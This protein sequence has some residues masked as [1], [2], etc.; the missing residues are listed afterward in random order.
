MQGKAAVRMVRI[1]RGAALA[2]VLAV[3][4]A[5]L[6]GPVSAGRDFTVETRLAE[7]LK[8]LGLFRG[9]SDTDF[10]LERPLSRVESVVMLIRLLG[11]EEEALAQQNTHPFT[12]VPKWADAQIGYAYRNGLANGVSETEFGIGEAGAATYLTLVL[13]ALG[14]SDRN[15]EDFSWADPFP[16]AREAGIL[17]ELVNTTE[18]L[19]G[20]VVTVSYAA[21]AA[22]CKDSDETLSDRL[23]ASGVFSRELYLQQYDSSLFGNGEKAVLPSEALGML[24]DWIEGHYTRTVSEENDP[25]I[26]LYSKDISRSTEQQELLVLEYSK[27][28]ED[29]FLSY[30]VFDDSRTPVT[31]NSVSL[32]IYD[33]GGSFSVTFYTQEDE[34]MEGYTS[35]GYAFPEPETADYDRLSFRE[36]SGKQQTADEKLAGK[37]LAH[38]LSVTDAFLADEKLG[39]SMSDFGFSGY[40]G[41]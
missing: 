34:R 16:L 1:R 19:R 22:R 9:V 17:P 36:Y 7:T 37:Y 6:S 23:I 32:R 2:L 3:L 10:A 41:R 24:R 30:R 8:A 5:L 12:D 4:L 40:E 35:R 27:R 14:Y 13:R 21:L 31:V 33:D 18:F 15:S 26:Y 29:V 38:L 25:L 28:Y 20:D 11:R 39:C